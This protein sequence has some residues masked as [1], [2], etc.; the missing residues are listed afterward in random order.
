[1]WQRL[2]WKHF[3]ILLVVLCVSL[4]LFVVFSPAN[5]LMRWY[6]SD[7]A[8]YYYKIAV[9]INEGRGITFDGVNVTNGFQPLWMA[10]CVPV[11]L[12]A[13]YDLILP[14]RVL[15]FISILFSAGT[16]VLFFRF[17]QKVI[18]P[19]TAA[20]VAL[21]W[22]FH[23]EI[24][25]VVV[26][27]GMEA[28]VGAFFTIL[29]LYLL[30][31]WRGQVLSTKQIVFLGLVGGLTILSR[32]DN[33]FLVFLLGVWFVLGNKSGYLRNLAVGDL[34][35]VF[36]SGL[37]TY[38]IRL[39][40]GAF[41][42]EFSASLPV[43]V[44]L[45]FLLKPALFYLLGLYQYPETGQDVKRLTG[46]V[47]LA[48]SIFSAVAGIVL[49]SLWYLDV[50]PNIKFSVIVID[51]T[52]T[53]LGAV[54]L[55][56]F[57]RL[58]FKAEDESLQRWVFWKEPFDRVLK[59]FT[60]V[61]LLLGGYLLWN[62]SYAGTFMPI[63]G[64]IK[65]WWA[66]LQNTIYGAKV[67]TLG[68][69]FGVQANFN[70]WKLAFSPFVH[71]AEASG[72]SMPEILAP[73][74]ST[75]VIVFL[76]AVIILLV[77]SQRNRIAGIGDVGLFAMF[78]SLYSHIFYYTSTTYLHVRNWYWVGEM[79][80]T[81]IVFGILL[82]C[83][84]WSVERRGWGVGAWNVI[85]LLSGIFIVV[86]FSSALGKIV[87]WKVSPES[88]E[89]FLMEVRFLE[90]NTEPGAW[91]G[92]TGGGIVAYFITDRT[93]INLDG[94][95]NSPEY[96]QLLKRGQAS[97]FLDKIGV[98]YI[99]DNPYVVTETDPYNTLLNGRLERVERLDRRLL[100]RYL[101]P[102]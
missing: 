58:F 19:I 98:D 42:Q 49:F 12:L 63:S 56:L 13:K 53:V 1:M 15:A 99:Y 78:L 4:Q 26:Q 2:S 34:A 30:V 41:Y 79:F 81:V 84:R 3:E 95:V 10:I 48:V 83:I 17:L 64:Q 47:L 32:L 59:F 52:G 77:I 50:M 18:A 6:Q 24:H 76:F 94:L 96:F 27:N 60:P 51:W 44:G 70:A 88:R 11:F 55:R 85:A 97:S 90:A 23:L 43:L 92:T 25:E 69:L 31:H 20:L 82:E 86:S 91:I 36:I 29:F 67:D 72:K 28:T 62:H 57:L 39:R 9:N 93:I 7:D 22:T 46:R 35:L 68:Q 101:P 89:T 73:V 8:F 80:F 38:Y 75:I 87:P 14:L 66:G 5:S 74:V 45:G 33:V 54:G 37:L 71:L 21:L 40:S 65:H 102:Q 61:G 100:Y 16:G